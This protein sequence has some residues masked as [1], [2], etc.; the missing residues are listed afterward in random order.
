MEFRLTKKLSWYNELG[1]KYRQSYYEQVDRDTNFIKS[2]GL[3][4]KTEFRYYFRSIDKNKFT[5][6]YVALN[7]F[8]INDHHNIEIDYYYQGDSSIL[9]KDA[10]G[11]K[12]K[13]FGIN[14]IVGRQ[15]PLTN[16]LALDL[17]CGLGIRL[18][19]IVTVNKEFERYR[20]G[21]RGPIDVNVYFTKQIVEAG[22][23]HSAGLNIS[24]G[25]R[26]CYS[27]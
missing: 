8:F 14:L 17:Y 22:A 15:K 10:F 6:R 1:I 24:L 7:G 2:K 26:L 13:V 18:R 5:G 25:L 12:K 11:V 9:R 3:K 27:L 21:L 4:I 19:N 20:D 23:A 16:R